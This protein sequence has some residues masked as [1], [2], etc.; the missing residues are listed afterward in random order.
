MDRVQVLNMSGLYN[1]E[2][3]LYSF[4]D[5]RFK[6]PV[7]LSVWLYTAVVFLIFGLPFIK[8]T[9]GFDFNVYKLAIAFGI[10]FAAGNFMAKPI[11][12]GRPF[13]AAMKILITYIINEKIYFD[14]KASKELPEYKIDEIHLISRRRDFNKLFNM[15]YQEKRGRLYV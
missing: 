4:F 2:I 14:N 1:K 5:I 12:N 13:F 6:T 10:P 11:F 8:L 7:R 9:G 3:M 15:K